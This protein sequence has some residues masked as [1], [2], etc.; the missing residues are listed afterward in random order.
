MSRPIAVPLILAACV[1]PAASAVRHASASDRFDGTW[2][3]E[4]I[5][6]LG[7]CDR[8]YRYPVRVDQGRARIVGTAF[9]VTGG[10]TAKGAVKGAITNGAATA[11][12]V[13]RLGADGFGRGTWTA[14]GALDCRGHWNAERR[15]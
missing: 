5:T 15:G 6:D 10:V 9:A 8:A 1:V 7:T 14:T 13:G 2:S 11:Q 3:V 12:I 4:I